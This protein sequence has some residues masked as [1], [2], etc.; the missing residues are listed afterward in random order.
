MF[1]HEVTNNDQIVIVVRKCSRCSK[2]NH[3]QA[4]R[5][6]AVHFFVSNQPLISGDI[7]LDMTF[8]KLAHIHFLIYLIIFTF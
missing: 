4:S 2:N 1:Q 5:K 3:Y 6:K 8:R 7:E